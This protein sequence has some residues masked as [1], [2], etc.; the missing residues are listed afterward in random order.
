VKFL[1]DVVVGDAHGVGSLAAR[2]DNS[3]TPSEPQPPAS[4]D[5]RIVG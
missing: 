1:G 3:E 5:R 4:G 2:R